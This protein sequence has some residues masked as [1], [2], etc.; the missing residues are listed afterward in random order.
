MDSDARLA[1][2]ECLDCPTQQ[3]FSLAQKQVFLCCIYL[4]G[5]LLFGLKIKVRVGLVLGF[6]V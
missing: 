6:C 4:T 5:R 3:L 2:E 1:A